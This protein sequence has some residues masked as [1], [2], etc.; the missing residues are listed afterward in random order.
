MCASVYVCAAKPMLRCILYTFSA[1]FLNHQ[2]QPLRRGF[3][4]KRHFKPSTGYKLVGMQ[5]PIK[6][7]PTYTDIMRVFQARECLFAILHI[8]DLNS[9]WQTE[10]MANREQPSCMRSHEKKNKHKE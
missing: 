6:H 2:R 5:K 3:S 7:L 1:L 4:R 8:K 10:E 9:R